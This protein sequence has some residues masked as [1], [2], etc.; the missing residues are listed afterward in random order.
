MATLTERLQLIVDATTSKAEASFQRLTGAAEST[1]KAATASA[2]DVQAA[3]DRVA[4]ARERELQAAGALTVAQKRL[5][6]LRA[7]GRARASQLE[8]AENKVAAAQRAVQLSAHGAARAQTELEATQRDAAAAAE[9][10]ARGLGRMS[11]AMTGLVASG[12]ALAGAKLGSV[13]R[14]A[15]DGFTEGARSAGLFAT[16][17][18]SSVQEAGAFLGLVGTLGLDLNDLLEI[19]AEYAQKAAAN[20]DQLKALGAET[21]RN[22]DGTINWTRS[23]T[24]MLE[25]LQRIPDATE[26]N[27]LGFQYFGEEGYK[28]LSRLVAS[29]VDVSDALERIGTPFSDED[30]RAAQEYDAALLNLDLASTRASNA[31][32]RVLVPVVTDVAEGLGDVVEAAEDVGPV[33]IAATAAAIALGVTGFTPA[34]AAGARLAAVT[35]LVSRNLAL[36]RSTAALAGGAGGR[37]AAGF[38]VAQAGAGRLLGLVGGP[39]G[40]ALIGLSVVYEQASDGAEAFSSNVQKATAELTASSKTTKDL[41]KN[42]QQMAR[43]LAEESGFWENLAARRRAAQEVDTPWWQIGAGPAATAAFADADAAARGYELAI[44]DAREELGE[45]GAQQTASEFATRSLTDMIAAGTTSGQEF[46]DAVALAADNQ[47]KQERSSGL[48]EAAIAAYNAVTRDATE[49]TLGLWQA[50][51]TQRDGL[52]GLQTAIKDAASTVQDSTTPWDDVQAAIDDVISATLTYADQSADAAV[53]AARASRQVVDAQAEAAIRGRETLRTLY[54]TLQQPGITAGA[55]K[56]VQ[57]LIHDLQ[58]AQQNGDVEAV[59]RLTGA[60][61]ATG[62]L[63]QATEDRD[64]TIRV[65][66]RN[67]PAVDDYLNRL[68]DRQRLSLIRV[69][70]RNGPA[71]DTYLDGLATQDRL[72]IIRVETRGGPAVDAYLDNLA[73]QTRV[74]RIDARAPSGAPGGAGLA[75]MRGAPGVGSYGSSGGNVTIQSMT[76]QVAAEGSSGRLTQSSLAAAGRQYV[77]AIQTY[78][79]QNGTGWRAGGRR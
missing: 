71:V 13:L 34:A 69:E 44:Q 42:S 49:T 41:T 59:L 57:D 38:G 74:A 35:A 62:E 64:T 28:Q 37:L 3:A 40:A 7:T 50:Q 54:E 14:D 46:A 68:A 61:E 36:Y 47:A 70:S 58:E 15:A 27:R 53:A 23:L 5:D 16:S 24:V 78:E 19:Q 1:G 31:L 48:A 26:R 22:S 55:R 33:V 17:T 45:F 52:R 67:G 73:G 65:E 8:A 20:T 11:G 77:A 60:A 43:Q 72:A 51:L 30:V 10:S 6:E 2:R 18:N 32:G 9:G 76:V 75:G 12:A 79:R 4:A 29:G 39:L 66:S 63:D 56:Q 21:Q 25:A